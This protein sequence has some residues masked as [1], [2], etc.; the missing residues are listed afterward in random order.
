ME[1]LNPWV[2][3]GALAVTAAVLYSA[4]AAAFVLAPSATL[5]FFDA[6]FHGLNLADLQAGAKPFTV[7]GFVYGLA[8]IVAYAFVSGVVFAACYNLLRR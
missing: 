3:G 5:G 7:G 6:W 2:V 4:C 1:K 8:G